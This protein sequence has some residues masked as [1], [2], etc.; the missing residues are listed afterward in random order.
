VLDVIFTPIYDFLSKI[1]SAIHRNV[2]KPTFRALRNLL[3]SIF[4]QEKD[5]KVIDY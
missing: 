1:I 2:T 5:N 3:N 4:P